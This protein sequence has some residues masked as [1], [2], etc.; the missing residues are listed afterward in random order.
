MQLASHSSRPVRRSTC[1][2]LHS[3]RQT[4]HSSP[5]TAA[6][7]PATGAFTLSGDVSGSGSTAI[8]TTIGANKV[9]LA[10]IAQESAPTRFSATQPARLATS[11]L[12]RPRPSTSAAALEPSPTA[13]I[14]QPSERSSTTAFQPAHPYRAS[15]HYRTLHCRSRNQPA[16][17]PSTPLVIHSRPTRQTRALTLGGLTLSNVA[18]A[19]P[20]ACTLIL[21]AMFRVPAATAARAEAASPA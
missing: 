12:S 17:R 7:S 20:S 18:P 1:Q 14:R 21:R 5:T 13:S 15:Q 6:T 3:P 19:Q 10:D 8:T 9:S 11:Q 4:S 2:R 16:S